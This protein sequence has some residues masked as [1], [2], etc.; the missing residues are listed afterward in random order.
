MVT[1]ETNEAMGVCA[2]DTLLLT[3]NVPHI[4]EKIFFSLDYKSFK[5]CKDV[6][7]TWNQ[8]LTSESFKL[9]R[10]SVFRKDIEEDLWEAILED[11]VDG[12]RKI[13]S[14]DMDDVNFEHRIETNFRISYCKHDCKHGPKECGSAHLI[15]APIQEFT[16]LT[17]LN[18]AAIKGCTEMVKLLMDAGADPKT[19]KK[20]K[21]SPLH[22]AV[23]YG[24]I[25]V[26]KVLLD[27][28]ANP[29]EASAGG[30]TMLY[31]ATLI[32]HTAHTDVV[33]LLLNMGAN[34]NVPNNF[35]C[36]P[37]HC[38]ALSGYKDMVKFLLDGGAES[39]LEDLSGRT[40]LSLAQDYGHMDVVNMLRDAGAL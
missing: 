24:H 7:M 38:A 2:F 34:P 4:L 32:G 31:L 5:N 33:Q 39:S 28:G 14:N 1:L 30:T 27:G 29:D 20:Y 35:G 25:D 23:L 12:V 8:L 15:R 3:R 37:L 26:V 17:P 19:V 6:S 22:N 40:P 11:N 21:W 10:K 13:I 16:E 9:I 36:T 18:L